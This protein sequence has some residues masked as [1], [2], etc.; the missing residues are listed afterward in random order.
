[1]ASHER[2]IAH[3]K[4]GVS[5]EALAPLRALHREPDLSRQLL[6]GRLPMDA[7]SFGFLDPHQRSIAGAVAGPSAQSDHNAAI[8]SLINGSSFLQSP[9]TPA[10]WI[11]QITD[12]DLRASAEQSLEDAGSRELHRNR[13]PDALEPS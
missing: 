3:L 1:M 12:D 5:D 8:A 10:A 6:I 11:Q 9:E 7:A 2:G 4:T 13:T